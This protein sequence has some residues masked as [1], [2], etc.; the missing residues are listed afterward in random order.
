MDFVRVAAIYVRVGEGDN[1]HALFYM[2]YL[3]VRIAV[4]DLWNEFVGFAPL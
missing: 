2:P 1:K 4:L 3:S